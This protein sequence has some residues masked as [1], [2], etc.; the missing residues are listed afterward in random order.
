MTQ[1]ICVERKTFRVIVAAR[2]KQQAVSER[3][4][5]TREPLRINLNMVGSEKS[6]NRD[7]N[8]SLS[9]R[10][11]H[12]IGDP[13]LRGRGSSHGPH[14][15]SHTQCGS[16][17]RLPP[18]CTQGV[19]CFAFAPGFLARGLFPPC[20]RL[21]PRGSLLWWWRLVVVVVERTE[22]AEEEVAHPVAGA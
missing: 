7:M 3:P 21:A 6:L 14:T 17:F 2:I 13:G 19:F 20:P 16:T 22:A 18:A 11:A 5:G 4:L 10:P 1:L 8:V 9:S 15:A 12:D